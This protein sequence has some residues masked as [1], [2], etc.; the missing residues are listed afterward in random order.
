MGCLA[1]KFI[2]ISYKNNVICME[3]FGMSA[4]DKVVT[5]LPCLHL[6]H[7]HC[8]I[9]RWLR[10]RANNSQ[11]Q[12]C[13][14]CRYSMPHLYLLSYMIYQSSQGGGVEAEVQGCYV[15]LGRLRLS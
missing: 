6:F 12:T 2:V 7:G 3:E 11:S 5:R 13:P 1:Y 9:L 15:G 14:L 4:S 10:D 8:I